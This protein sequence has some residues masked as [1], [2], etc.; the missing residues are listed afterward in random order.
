MLYL[1]CGIFGFI[2]GMWFEE[3]YRESITHK[4]DEDNA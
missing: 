4:E 1:L 3:W 2:V